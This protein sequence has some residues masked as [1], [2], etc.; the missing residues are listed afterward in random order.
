MS[1]TRVCELDRL[2]VERGVCALV[3]GEQV[4]LFRTVTDEVFALANRDPFSGAMVL[5]R[6]IVGS[7]G[8][9][10][11]V[12]SPMYKQVFAL[13]SGRCLDDA[14]VAVP[15]H[16]VRVRDGAV[17]VQPVAALAELRKV[18]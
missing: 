6:G 2:P 16:G 7:R 10:A 4:A 18:S 15:V 17:E 8:D 14:E 1:W 11:T 12:A 9:T 3:G 13:D 5:S